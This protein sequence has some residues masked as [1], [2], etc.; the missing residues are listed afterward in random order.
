MVLQLKHRPKWTGDLYMERDKHG[1][2]HII[3]P[4]GLRRL[5]PREDGS[6]LD[7]PGDG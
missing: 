1:L 5:S 6:N 4:S 2:E 3:L 7:K